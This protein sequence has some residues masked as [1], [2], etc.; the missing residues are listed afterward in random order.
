MNLIAYFTL[1]TITDLENSV[2]D[3]KDQ[4]TAAEERAKVL[5]RAKLRVDTLLQQ[6]KTQ[7]ENRV[8]DLQGGGVM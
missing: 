5:D 3:L 2:S 7:G 1:Q 4:L 8:T 6:E